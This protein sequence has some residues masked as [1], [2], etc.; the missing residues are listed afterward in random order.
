MVRENMAG[1]RFY[2]SSML[3]RSEEK[4]EEKPA[5]PAADIQYERKRKYSSSLQSQDKRV[6]E[7]ISH[8]YL[9]FAKKLKSLG[10]KQEKIQK[11][12]KIIQKID[13]YF[14]DEQQK[15]FFLAQLIKKSYDGVFDDTLFYSV[16]PIKMLQHKICD[17]SMFLKAFNRVLNQVHSD[18]DK[19]YPY[20]MQTLGFFLTICR[21]KNILDLTQIK[22]C[23]SKV[24]SE[25][26]QRLDN[27]FSLLT[28]CLICLNYYV[29]ARPSLT[30]PSFLSLRLRATPPAFFFFGGGSEFSLPCSSTNLP[31][32]SNAPQ[33]PAQ[34]QQMR[35]AWENESRAMI[36]E[37]IINQLNQFN[38]PA[39]PIIQLI[40]NEL[41]QYT[42]DFAKRTVFE[43]SKQTLQLIHELV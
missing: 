40:I 31:L 10:S 29:S 25:D 26:V 37:Q 36:K 32:A 23:F 15:E 43:E 12:D 20:M 38:Q 16:I 21:L 11:I 42:E 33:D 3:V 1:F 7:Y 19:Y 6:T 5:K 4:K 18:V 28:S 41:V 17:T 27:T 39:D 8:R 13:V 2:N 22:L 24:T 14:R 34:R 9:M 30:A 35:T